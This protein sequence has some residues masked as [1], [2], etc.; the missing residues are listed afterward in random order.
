MHILIAEDDATLS[1][2]LTRA[3]RQSGYAV[4]CVEDGE[5][6][7]TA[8]V[9][10]R[11]DLLILDLGL[12]LLSGLEVL[13]RARARRKAADP[14]PYRRGWRGRPRARPR[15]GRGRLHG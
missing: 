10:D 8:L 3:L 5:R 4:D 13:R 2:G 7:D 11:F 12:P 15:S 9:G 1:D 6:A 14:D